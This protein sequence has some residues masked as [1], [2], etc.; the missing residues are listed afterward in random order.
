MIEIRSPKTT[1]EWD[2]YYDLRYRVLQQ[3]WKQP[4]SSAV[5]PEDETATHFA[6]FEDLQPK[7]IARVDFTD[8]EKQV[9]VRFVAVETNVQGKGY[10][11]Q[12][13]KAIE[14]FASAN[15]ISEIILEARENEVPFY[16]SLG[17]AITTPGKLLFE[18]I[19]HFWMEKKI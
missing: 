19:P 15:N 13:M 11:K 9:Q 18:S 4:R 2:A 3:P 10:G 16:L 1:A 17:Y 7:A 5:T 8:R 14:Q 6:L 12:L